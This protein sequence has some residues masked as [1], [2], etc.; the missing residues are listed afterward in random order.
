MVRPHIFPISIFKVKEGVNYNPKIQT[1]IFLSAA[2]KLLQSAFSQT[3]SLSMLHS[4]SKSYVPGNDYRTESQLWVAVP[5]SLAVFSPKVTVFRP[6][7][8]TFSFTTR[9]LSSPGH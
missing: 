8:V 3:S 2:W 5:A 4:I 9:E 6:D 1:T 7:A